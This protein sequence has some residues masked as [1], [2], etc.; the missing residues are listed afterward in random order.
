MNDG[1]ASKR[2]DLVV[3]IHGLGR[4]SIVF[5]RLRPYLRRAGYDVETYN[6]PS[7]RYGAAALTEMLVA[8]LTRW[9]GAGRRVHMVGHSMGGILIRGALIDPPP[10]TLGRIVMIGSPNKGAGVLNHF[11]ERLFAKRFFGPASADLVIGSE[12]LAG[13]GV[14]KAEIGVIAGT[15]R[16]HLLNPIAYVNHF[17]APDVPNDGTVEVENTHLDGMAD[18]IALPANHTIMCQHPRVMYQV[19]AFLKDG[20]F[21]HGH[22][23]EV[24]AQ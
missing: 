16:W 13:L 2:R 15:T 21:D 9:T 11:G 1:S 19:L 17:L 14:P 12:Y 18:F 22:R 24:A 7:T 4:S 23:Y 10:F 20:R 5:W 8:D 6:Y 3:L